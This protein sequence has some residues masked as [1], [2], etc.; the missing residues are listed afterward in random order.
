MPL[1]SSG[2]QGDPHVHCKAPLNS[3]RRRPPWN[4]TGFYWFPKEPKGSLQGTPEV[5]VKD[6]PMEC[7]WFLLVSKGILTLDSF[8]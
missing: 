5:H 4:A 7:H 6:A 3:R 1:V 8:I 2:F